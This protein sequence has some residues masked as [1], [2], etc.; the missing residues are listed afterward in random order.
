MTRKELGYT[1]TLTINHAAVK[2][3]IDKALDKELNSIYAALRITT[4]DIPP[5]LAEEWNKHV[6]DLAHLFEQLIAYNLITEHGMF[7]EIY[8]E[9]E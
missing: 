6:Q 5:V 7:I 8:N 4:G 9:E 1:S 3:F 2:S